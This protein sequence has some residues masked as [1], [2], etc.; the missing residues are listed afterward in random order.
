[1]RNKLIWK[2]IMVYVICLFL[3]WILIEITWGIT[4]GWLGGS[5]VTDKKFQQERTR[6]LN[7]KGIKETD[8]PKTILGYE[9]WYKK[10]PP[11]VQ[12]SLE[13]LIKDRI[14]NLNWFS[15]TFFVS[16]FVFSIIGFLYGFLT[17]K[18]V[19][20]GLIPALSFFINN[21]LIRFTQTRDLNFIQ[22]VII[23]VIAQFGVCYL[24]GYLGAFRSRKRNKIQIIT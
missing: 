1:M 2:N 23:V 8:I 10:L 18:F 13:N 15:I 5:K 7:E 17:G 20:I 6:I 11:D 21:P 24:F 12:K 16:A 3:L 9:N 14:L 4:V 22:M 19:Y